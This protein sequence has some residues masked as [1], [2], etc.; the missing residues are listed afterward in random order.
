MI[1][2]LKICMFR[3]G[4][5]TPDSTVTIPLSAFQIAEKLIPKKL[6]TA[7]SNEGI[8]L[9]E[10]TSLFAKEGPRGNLIEIENSNERIV[11]SIE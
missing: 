6:K 8:D 4:K 7:L 2:T 1:Q 3:T 9:S 10:L 5:N 11:I